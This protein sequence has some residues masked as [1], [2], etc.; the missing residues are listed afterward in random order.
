MLALSLLACLRP[1]GLPA[2]PD[3]VPLACE[4]GL[5]VPP[6]GVVGISDPSLLEPGVV[7]LV[8]ESRAP[9]VR[10]EIHWSLVQPDPD[11]PLDFSAHDAMMARIQAQELQVLA[12]LS[13]VPP[14]Y[15]DD[16]ERIARDFR[17]FATAAVAR[18]APQGVHHW[19]VFN[20]PNLTGYGWL[21][22]ADDPYVNLP[23]YTRLL[24][25][26]NEVVREVDPE[27]VV[28]LGGIASDQHRG[29]PLEE[30]A[31]VLYGYGAADCF[32]VFAY[33]PYGYQNRFPEARD[34][35][36]AVLDVHDDAEKPVWFDEYGWT[37][38]AS[39]DLA[40][41]DTAETNPMLAVFAQKDVADALF[42]FSAKDYSGRPGRRPDPGGLRAEQAAELHDVP[43]SALIRRDPG[44][45]GRWPRR[46][47]PRRRCSRRSTLS[48][49]N[50]ASSASWPG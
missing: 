3:S 7:E 18:Y 14:A 33:H 41:N 50:C 9:W 4:R 15:G 24:G 10:A 47:T 42:W 5:V 45:V 22:D 43:A 32:D 16:W 12:I 38:Q 40:V 36:Q 28:V 44:L 13:W 46:T 6:T 17:A 19:E 30:V 39:M 20:E 26:A 11:G 34:R 23:N 29:L 49:E 25:I 1:D 27:G 2:L 35:V 8:G 48:G 37:D 21:T 31:D